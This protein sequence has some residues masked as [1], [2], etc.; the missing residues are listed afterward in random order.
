MNQHLFKTLQDIIAC[1]ASEEEMS[2][3]IDAVVM[4][5]DTEFEDLTHAFI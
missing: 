5:A 1:D 2:R 4:D 3:I